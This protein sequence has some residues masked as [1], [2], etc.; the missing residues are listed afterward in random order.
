MRFWLS[1]AHFS[2]LEKLFRVPQKNWIG[3]MTLTCFC[4]SISVL[5]CYLEQNHNKIQCLI[6][7]LVRQFLRAH[8]M[9]CIQIIW[10]KTNFLVLF[11]Y[12][13]NQHTNI[14]NEAIDN[15]TQHFENKW[16]PIIVE[17]DNRNDTGIF[18]FQ[19]FNNLLL[20]FKIKLLVQALINLLLECLVLY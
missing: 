9:K 8:Q 2:C 5:N 3:N 19:C 4:T 14:L 12:S 7:L 13:N 10:V 17:H 20:R 1:L 15:N 18:L 6:K 16:L 11:E